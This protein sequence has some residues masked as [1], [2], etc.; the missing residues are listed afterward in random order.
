MTLLEV[1]VALVVLATGVAA[2]QRLLAE[3]VGAVATDATLTRAMLLARAVLAEAEV[4]PPPLGHVEGDLAGRGAPDF[5]VAREVTA[6]PHPAL[7]QVTVRVWAAQR[8]GDAAEL[9]EV[10]RVPPR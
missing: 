7:R 4:A 1:L 5:R 8:P 10:L 2:L 9:V 6:T 3:S